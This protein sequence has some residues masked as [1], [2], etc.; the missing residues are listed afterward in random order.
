[1]KKKNINESLGKSHTKMWSPEKE[2]L[3]NRRVSTGRLKKLR[4]SLK[5]SEWTTG[6]I[7]K[8]SHLFLRPVWKLKAPGGKCSYRLMGPNRMKMI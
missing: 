3:G 4:V 2:E 5:K 6:N 1:M 7:V 8:V